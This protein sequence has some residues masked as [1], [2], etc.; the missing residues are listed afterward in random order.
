MTLPFQP[1]EQPLLLH[2]ADYNYE[3]WLAEPQI[4]AA[5][6]RLM[7]KAGCNVMSVG[8]FAWSMLEPAEGEYNF[9]WLDA[10]M[11]S[12]HANGL[13]A[14]L[15][16]PSGGKP[17]WLAQAYPE[18]RLVDAHGRREPQRRRHNHCPT[19]PVYRAKVRQINTLLAERYKAHPALLMWHLSNEYSANGCHCELCYAAFRRWLQ[20]RYGSLDALNHAWWTSFWSHRYSDWAQIEPVDPSLHGLMLDWQRFTSDQVID[21]CLAEIEPLRAI[22]PHIPLTT[23]FMT[24]NVGLDYWEFARYLDIVSWDSY[25]RWH[26]EA[27][28]WRVA[29]KSAFLHDLHRS[30]KRAPFLLMESTPSATNWQG[31][32]RPK[33]PGM[34]LLASLQAVA[35][36]ANGVQ[37]FQWRQSRGGEEK[38]HGAVVG[39]DGRDDTRVFQQVTQLGAQLAALP[40]LAGTLN[41]ADVAIIYDLQ[42]EWALGLA[43]L[44]RNVEKNYQEQCIAHYQPFWQ[45]GVTVDLA[46]STSDLAGYKLVIA[47]M[48]Y[49]LRDGVAQRLQAYV[50]AGGTLVL[51]YLSGLVDASDLC[52]VGDSPLRALLGLRVEETDVL[53][54]HHSQ[55][56]MAQAHDP[57]QEHELGLAGAWNV[58]HFADLV[59]VET[60]RVLATYGEPP[61]AGLPALTENRYGK[62][63]CYYLAARTDEAFLRD[64]YAGLSRQ[65]GLQPALPGP[66]P[67]GVTI[68]RRAQGEQEYLFVLNFLPCAQ[69]LALGEA[70]WVD[71]SSGEAVGERLRLEAYGVHVLCPAGQSPV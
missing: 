49:M 33:L 57:A 53:F 60:A 32:S 56:L 31:I 62:G 36:G 24:P 43:Q 64:F 16:T 45:Q 2:G 38:F 14:I 26:S 50:A 39:H 8:I 25:P 41:V 67:Q 22:T 61:Y 23:N 11:D 3:Q 55:T 51:T 34:H 15:A 10:L 13:R 66:L 68:Q 19:S 52:F 40:Q 58:S 30:F 35:H 28:E 63:R 12:L 42:N 7:R 65:L 1:H 29:V 48:L 5:D 18:T 70:P 59:Q 27:D 37:Y 47:P 4:L 21:F 71:A 44:S 17:A 20:A 9:A 54:A 46:D 6:L 69:E